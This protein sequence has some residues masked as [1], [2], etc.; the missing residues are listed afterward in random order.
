MTQFVYVVAD[1]SWKTTLVRPTAKCEIEN[2]PT[3]HGLITM[4]AMTETTKVTVSWSRLVCSRVF[5]SVFGSSKREKRVPR[6]SF[7][8]TSGAE[9]T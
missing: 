1:S 2:H 4:T 7:A 6:V 5:Q 3:P 9:V 8:W